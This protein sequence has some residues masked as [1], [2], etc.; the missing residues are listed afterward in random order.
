MQNKKQ[1]LFSFLSNKLG[2]TKMKPRITTMP[3]LWLGCSNPSHLPFIREGLNPIPRPFPS[4]GEGMQPLLLV[5]LSLR[6]CSLRSGRREIPYAT[7][8]RLFVRASPAFTPTLLYDR[9]SLT[10][11]RSVRLVQTERNAKQMTKF[12]VFMAEAHPLI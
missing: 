4:P 5:A 6:F 8:L 3:S 2:N 11:T 12:F 9:C 1:F 7:E 10:S